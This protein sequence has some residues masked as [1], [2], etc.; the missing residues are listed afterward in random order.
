MG[1]I[2]RQ[3]DVPHVIC[4]QQGKSILDKAAISFSQSFYSKLLAGEV[5]CKA[6][7]QAR[8]E[9]SVKFSD[10]EANR[11]QLMISNG[12]FKHK[13]KNCTTRWPR[14]KGDLICKSDHIKFKN[15]RAKIT[16]FIPREIE[17]F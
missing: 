1:E 4:S 5:I 11:F 13:P 3:C 14:K 8:D 2:F 6:F 7:Q 12:Q 15:M 9:V 17:F 10:E 16:N